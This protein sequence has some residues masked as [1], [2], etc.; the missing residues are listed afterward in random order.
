MVCVGL[1]VSEDG[2]R[3]LVDGGE[4]DEEH[5]GSAAPVISFNS[6]CYLWLWVGRQGVVVRVLWSGR[7]TIA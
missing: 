7:S 1:C 5:V 4:V 6:V 3:S 2:D